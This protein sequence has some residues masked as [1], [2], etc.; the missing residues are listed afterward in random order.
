M[1]MK[2]YWYRKL[3][4]PRPRLSLAFARAFV[5][6]AQRYLRFPLCHVDCR[7]C[8]NATLGTSALCPD[9]WENTN[10]SQASWRR[11]SGQ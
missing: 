4:C 1:Q 7:P 8:E 11:H 10:F 5:V 3:Y 6:H 2:M 9:G